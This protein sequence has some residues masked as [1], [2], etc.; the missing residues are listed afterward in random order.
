[1]ILKKLFSVMGLALSMLAAGSAGAAV[2]NFD[3]P[4]G[5]LGPSQAYGPITAYGFQLKKN[6]SLMQHDLVGKS[7]VNPDE[8]GLG[9]TE[10]MDSEITD[11]LVVVL[12]L[13]SQV[14]K[15]L[16]VQFGS[17]QAGEQWR[18]GF[19][20][21]GLLPSNI[22]Q[23]GSFQ[24]GSVGFPTF[25]DFGIDTSR[26]MIIEAAS[27]DVLLRSLVTSSA[28]PEPESVLLLGIGLAGVAV[29][30]RKASAKQAS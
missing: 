12:D 30:R 22:S 11:S 1:M 24:N 3:T 7:D 5:N 4:V 23:F 13:A 8:T 14:G 26:F 25:V 2:I 18:V 28:V 16:K 6:G 17:V 19:S 15:D 29:A 9:L 20:N 27:G 21:V 10:N